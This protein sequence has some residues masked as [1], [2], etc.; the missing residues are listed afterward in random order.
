MTNTKM[1]VGSLSND[2][3]RIASLSYRG[4]DKAA[5]I[6]LK[7]AKRWGKELVAQDTKEYIKKIAQEVNFISSNDLTK[8]NAEKFLM[9]SVLLQNYSLQIE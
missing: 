1:L 3:Q 2:L 8:E 4:S 9:Y 7:E 5:S 6:F